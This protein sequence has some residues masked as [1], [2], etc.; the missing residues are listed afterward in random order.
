MKKIILVF[1]CLFFCNADILNHNIDD[2]TIINLSKECNNG[3]GAY[4]SCVEML[5]KLKLG[6]KKNNMNY[7]GEYGRILN[8]D[9]DRREE[10]VSL[11]Y[12]ACKN[13]RPAYCYELYKF[14]VYARGNLKRAK[15]VA[16]IACENL[17]QSN[18]IIKKETCFMSKKIDECIKNTNDINPVK[19][20]IEAMEKYKEREN[21]GRK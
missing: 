8:V 14:D 12:K 3:N 17:G 18:E 11:L 4:G 16:Q 20:S 2:K 15:E 21:Y 5:E 19:C 6:C 9:F 7:C 13:G 1:V 10:S